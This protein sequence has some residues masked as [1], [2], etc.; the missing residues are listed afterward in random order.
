MLISD[1]CKNPNESFPPPVTLAPPLRAVATVIV[2]RIATI[3]IFTAYYSGTEK[4]T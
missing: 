4:R 2:V 3:K 1:G